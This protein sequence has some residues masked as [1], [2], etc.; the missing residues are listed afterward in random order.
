MTR[1][2]EARKV[3]V[4]RPDVIHRTCPVATPVV[5]DIAYLWN[6][7]REVFVAIVLLFEHTVAET[8]MLQALV[9]FMTLVPK[10]VCLHLD[11]FFAFLVV[12]GTIWFKMSSLTTV[13]T[14]P[15]RSQSLQ[16]LPVFR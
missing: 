9:V 1:T 6:E 5:T 10:C 13:S 15:L 14:A 7:D 11:V 3:N 16:C 2:D 4:T 8:S 12:S